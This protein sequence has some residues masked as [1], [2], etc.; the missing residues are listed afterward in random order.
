MLD[1]AVAERR[2]GGDARLV[3]KHVDRAH[4]EQRLR[5]P[6]EGPFQSWCQRAV[7]LVAVGNEDVMSDRHG[8]VSHDD[9][10]DRAK[11]TRIAVARIQPRD[12]ISM[13]CRG[14]TLGA[15]GESCRVSRACELVQRTATEAVS[16]HGQTPAPPIVQSEPTAADLHLH[17]AV[18]LAKVGD[19]IALLTIE[20]PQQR[21]QQHL[22]RYHAQL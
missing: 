12:G 14:P 7:G 18:P 21:R 11:T 9:I 8:S 1:D 2:A 5:Q 6:L 13:K 22:Q 3:S 17:H 10:V 4:L 20:P 19:H 16:Q 15:I